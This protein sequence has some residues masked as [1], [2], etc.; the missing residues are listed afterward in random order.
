MA[1]KKEEFQTLL[2]REGLD[3]FIW[4]RSWRD[5]PGSNVGL[6]EMANDRWGCVFQIFPPVY[7]GTDTERRLGSFFNSLEVPD[8]SSV[9]LFAFASRN[10]T[11]FRRSYI[12]EHSVFTEKGL[13]IENIHLL[14]EM[15]NNREDWIKKHSNINMFSKGNDLRLRN[16]INLVCV[17]IPRYKKD[18][19]PYSEAELVSYFSKIEQ[20][21]SEFHPRKFSSREWVAI[22]REIL[23]PDNPLWFPP[24]DQLNTLNT[25]VVDN[26][27]VMVLEDNTHSIGIG[28]ILE[29]SEANKVKESNVQRSIMG[30][31]FEQ[32]EE[33][34]TEIEERSQGFLANF[35]YAISNLFSKKEKE[36]EEQEV[37]TQWHA[38]VYTTKMFPDKMSLFQMS[39]KFY[40]FLGERVSPAVPC[41]FFISLTLF[42]E[43]REKIKNSVNETVKWNLWQ[44]Q[45]LG[46]AARFFPNILDRA[47][48]SEIINN[49]LNDGEAPIY[50]SWMCCI[51]DSDI[52][53][54]N[55]FGELLKKNFLRDNWILQEESLIQ[56]LIFLAHLPMNFEPYI[57]V[58]FSKR[59][60]T[61]FTGNAAAIT[62][63]V[64]GEKG[65]GMPILSYVD[66]GG[67]ISGMDIFSS[68]TNY[69]FVVIGTS[70]SGKSF[71]MSDFFTNYL[72][73]GAKIRVIDVGR[74]YRS[75]CDLVGGQYIEFTEE[76]RMCL[77]FFTNIQVDKN[78]N[79]IHE[80][81]LQTIIP[82][83]AL[84]AMQSV[85]PEDAEDL[86]PAVLVG[87]IS[88]SITM[89]FETKHR[90]AGMQDVVESLKQIANTQKSSTGSIDILLQQL[91]RSLYPFGDPNGEY[92]AYFNGASNLNFDSDFVVLELEELDKKEQLKMV[93]LAAISHIVQG[94]FFLSDRSQKKILAVDE[95]W[96]IMSNKIIMRFLETAARRL[97]KYKG[98][99]GII[100]QSV[101]DFFK[102]PATEAVFNNSA[103]KF[104]LMQSGESIDYAEKRGDLSFE[105]G[106]LALM[107][108]VKSRSPLYSEV[109]IKHD[110]GNYFIGRLIVD[111]VAY[112]VYTTDA[113]DVSKVE[114]F[115]KEYGITA[116]DTRIIFGYAETKGIPPEDEYRERKMQGKLTTI[117]GKI[118]A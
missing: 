99:S 13:K 93:V 88:Q 118:G 82:L 31:A 94:E 95:A 107:K 66:R 51:M 37:S 106:F 87:Y 39:E 41:P 98:A 81:E 46:S 72:M 109:L 97:R 103:W 101:S 9:Q 7:A 28:H 10:L 16:F 69:N 75:L 4:A 34:K 91:I 86:D 17:T 19:V 2:E 102:N 33:E 45:S 67:Q 60:N 92:Y 5:I 40:D 11:G 23:I 64:T 79:K 77:N 85:S 83:V 117:A 116:V 59:M 113:H 84:M 104:F 58:D 115:S 25:Q 49:L 8:K 114:S 55:E 61:L 29:K 21:L 36:V 27:S 3:D 47:R 50:G 38:K 20:G 35:S 57:L 1:I 68:T 43:N 62:P 32:N 52:L 53:K 105:K 63:I 44:T 76:A 42:Y 56:H 12:H 26:N 15:K 54:V 111:K 71:T 65:S 108:T 78:T 100:T 96:S 90:N 48:E 22:M 6:Y 112:W 70:G 110:S 73:A 18:N 80:D 89:A 24:Q 14:E 30:D 74:S